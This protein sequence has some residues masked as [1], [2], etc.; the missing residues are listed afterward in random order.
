MALGYC[1]KQKKGCFSPNGLRS[2]PVSGFPLICIKDLSDSLINRLELAG[3]TKSGQAQ[4]RVKK[5]IVD[6]QASD[7]LHKS[8]TKSDLSDFRVIPQDNIR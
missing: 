4:D 1:P 5:K 8:V 2:C 6:P 3:A 7:S